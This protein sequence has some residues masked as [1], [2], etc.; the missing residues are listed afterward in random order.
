MPLESLLELVETLRTRI[1][2]HGAAL[3]QSEALTRY[4]LIDPLLRELGWNTEDPTLVMPEYRLGRGYADYAL[5]SDGRPM[6]MV[7]AKKLSTPLHEAATQGIGYCIED[8][9]GYFAVTDGKLWEL[10]ETHRPVPIDQKMVVSFDVE[11]MT[12]AEVCLKALALWRS[13]VA[14]RVVSPAQS[15]VVVLR[16]EPAR[17]DPESS[18]ANPVGQATRFSSPSVLSPTI[19]PTQTPLS[20]APRWLPISEFK[21]RKHTSPP[22]EIQFPDRR[23][24]LIKRWNM[25]TIEITRWLLENEFLNQSNWNI[26]QNVRYFVSDSKTHSSGREFKNPHQVGPLWVEGDFTG[27]DHVKNSCFV[28]RSVGQ[29][30]S[31]FKVRLSS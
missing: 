31:Q 15:P 12:T 17:N 9:I 28:I 18:L 26:R 6:I 23:N 14:N 5:L 13:S 3:R 25:I 4:A 11:G 20:D 7:E 19:Q 27:V 30:P 8:G 29:D 22:I 24:T 1:D 21:P 2:E 16:P 10:Y